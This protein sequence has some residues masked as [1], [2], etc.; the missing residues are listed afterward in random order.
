[1][2]E[3]ERAVSASGIFGRVFIPV[4]CE[5]C[6]RA[7]EVAA[8]E[9]LSPPH[10]PASLQ[11]GAH[12]LNPPTEL[13]MSHVSPSKADP[14]PVVDSFF[15]A[16]VPRPLSSWSGSGSTARHSSLVSVCDSKVRKSCR[17][18]AI[19]KGGTITQLRKDSRVSEWTDSYFPV[20]VQ[21]TFVQ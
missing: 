16:W 1:M 11:D 5:A 18:Y 10:T 6:A 14:A 3:V 7:R 19:P 15:P 4:C 9:S 12:P 8:T 20:M 21:I 2:L 13:L 17:K